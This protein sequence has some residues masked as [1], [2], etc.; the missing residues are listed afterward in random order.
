[1]FKALFFVSNYLGLPCSAID[2]ITLYC[3]SFQVRFV[4]KYREPM[5]VLVQIFFPLLYIVIGLSIINITSYDIVQDKAYTINADIYK[6]IFA[7]EGLHTFSYINNTGQSVEDLIQSLSDDANG[8]LQLQPGIAFKD[9]LKTMQMT[10][11]DFKSKSDMYELLISLME[12][13]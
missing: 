11:F 8:T 4:R 3:P 7:E 5:A 9:L 13:H 12:V 1:M 6:D 2:K 10:M